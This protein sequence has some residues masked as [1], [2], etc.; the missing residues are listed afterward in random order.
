[1]PNL[2]LQNL[3][4]GALSAGCQLSSTSTPAL[5]ATYAVDDDSY[6]GLLE[7]AFVVMSANR[8]PAGQS[9]WTILDMEGQP[10]TFGTTAQFLQFVGALADYR[11]ALKMIINGIPGAP[12]ALPSPSISI[13]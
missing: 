9:S 7:T 12:T 6:L 1:M 5:D 2:Y 3:A 10:R 4:A 11:E 8:F 13:P